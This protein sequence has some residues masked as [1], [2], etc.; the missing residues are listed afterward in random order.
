MSVSV[1]AP[2]QYQACVEACLEC[3][4]DCRVCLAK[5]AGQKSMNDC[6]LCCVQCIPVLKASIALM[7]AGSRY[8]KQQCELCA[9]ICD[10]CAEQ[11]GAHDHEHCQRC[12]ESCRKCAEACRKMAA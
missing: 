4:I 6:P 1:N 9:E 5:M 2:N 10:Y 11:C 12:A 3:L 7:T 8:S